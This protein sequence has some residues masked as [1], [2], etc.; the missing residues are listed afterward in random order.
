MSKN[1]LLI[2]IYVSTSIYLN[3][4]ITQKCNNWWSEILIGKIK[5]F[6][7]IVFLAKRFKIQTSTLNYVGFSFNCIKMT[8]Q[9]HQ[10]FVLFG[11]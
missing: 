6:Y 5:T 4:K 9:F 1:G 2:N 11:F 8:V 3:N 7:N 10:Y